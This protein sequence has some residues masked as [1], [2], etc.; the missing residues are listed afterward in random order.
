MGFAPSGARIT[1]ISYIVVKFLQGREIFAGRAYAKKGKTEPAVKGSIFPL[2]ALPGA[3]SRNAGA[4]ALSVKT[5]QKLT[6]V[7]PPRV[8]PSAFQ[9]S[10]EIVSE[11]KR[12]EPS[13]SAV[14]TPPE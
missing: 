2:D 11:K 8:E 10:D 1:V 9:T 6:F 3:R 13:P 5:N 14:F 4:H 7:S 12:T